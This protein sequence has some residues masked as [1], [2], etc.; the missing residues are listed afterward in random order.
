[1]LNAKTIKLRLIEESDAEFVLD[2][3]CD[4]KLNKYLSPVQGNIQ[5]QI[6]F[7]RNYKKDERAGR[8]FY[9]IIERRDTGVR[10]GTVRLY[11]F[12]GK[13]FC[14]GSWILNQDKTRMAALESALL[15]YEYGFQILGFESSHFEVAKANETVISFHERLGALR[16]KEDEVNIYFNITAGQFKAAKTKL[17]L[18]LKIHPTQAQ[19]SP[20]TGRE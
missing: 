14:W 20:P 6:E 18:K 12:Q 8:Q 7:I 1:M 2:L 10:C 19:N 11:D 17:E 4:T 5:E 9:F 13:S 15:V 16:S 3:R